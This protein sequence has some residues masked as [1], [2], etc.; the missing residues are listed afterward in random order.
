VT[1]N[2]QTVP[3]EGDLLSRSQTWLRGNPTLDQVKGAFR[4]IVN[5]IR[6]GDLVRTKVVEHTADALTEYYVDRG[7]DLTTLPSLDELA[8][9]AEAT[10]VAHI[11]VAEPD[12][13]SLY[14][15]VPVGKPLSREEKQAAISNLK[16][17]L[18]RPEGM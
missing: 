7:G 13:G 5:Q 4:G 18:R 11:Q 9:V 14:P 10:P 17:M 15:D 8:L 6:K 16:S 2:S 12:Y 3:R 1:I